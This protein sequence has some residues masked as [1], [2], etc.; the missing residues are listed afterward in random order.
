MFFFFFFFLMIRRP[1]RSTLFPYTTL[2]RSSSCSSSATTSAGSARELSPASREAHDEPGQH[3]EAA[4][5]GEREEHPP[6]RLRQGP[7]AGQSLSARPAR[8]DVHGGGGGHEDERREH[9]RHESDAREPEGIVEEIEGNDRHQARES[10][11]LPAA[12]VHAL[13]DLLERAGEL[14]FRPVATDG[15]GGEESHGG[16]QGAAHEGIHRAPHGT[17]ENARRQIEG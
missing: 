10:D 12:L 8:V 11:E 4:Q 7:L 2:F 3:G 9:V 13:L 5:R 1:P 15:A 16:A 6:R 17:E 14:L